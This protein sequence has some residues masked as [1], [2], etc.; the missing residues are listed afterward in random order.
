M[1][2]TCTLALALAGCAGS[3]SQARPEPIANVV[4]GAARSGALFELGVESLGP[5]TGRTPANQDAL[6]HLLGG[7][8]TVT[9]VD[10]SG[11]E[12][13]VFRDQEL[14]FYVIPNDDGS[15]FN[16]HVTSGKLAI[17][18]HPEWVIQS[19][20]QHSEP[21]TA[22]ECWGQHPVCFRSG[23]HV[24]VA[25]EISCDNLAT[26]AERLRLVGVPI[27]RAVWSPKPFGGPSSEPPQGSQPP[28]LSKIFSGKQ[29]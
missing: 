10:R 25:F 17:V 6:Q 16:V 8:Y 27:Q 19:P 24:G 29:P 28:D 23:D 15:L 26:P 2:R 20:F 11:I 13:H 9:P 22:C 21:L 14:L 4:P 18:E 12:F 7:R 1:S 5:I 3:A